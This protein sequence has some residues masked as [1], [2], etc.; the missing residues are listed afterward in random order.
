MLVGETQYVQSAIFEKFSSQDLFLQNVLR[1]LM[2][3]AFEQYTHLMHQEPVVIF[4][5]K[6]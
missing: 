3:Q 4:F 5:M 1:G 2:A 6:K